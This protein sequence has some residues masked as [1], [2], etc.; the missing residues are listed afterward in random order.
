MFLEQLNIKKNTPLRNLTTFGI[1]GPARYYLRVE[2]TDALLK[3]WGAA[4][5]AGI[6]VFI[7]GGGSNILVSDYGFDGLVIH[8]ATRGIE[9]LA[10]DDKT[11][12]LKAAA[13]EILDDVIAQTT[14]SGWWGIENLSLI[15]GRVGAF[16]IQNVGAYG[17]DAGGVVQSV[18]VWDSHSQTI[19]NLPKSECQFGYRTSIFNTTQRGRYLILHV[20]IKLSK[21]GQPNL[22]YQGLRDFFAKEPPT[23]PGQM[24]SAQIRAAVTRIRKSKL[25]DP[26]E[27]GSAGSF[28]KNIILNEEEFARLQTHAKK[29]LP[30]N[31]ITKLNGFRERF[32]NESGIKIPTAYIIE[33]CGLKGATLGGAALSQNHALIMTNATGHATAAEVMRLARQVRQTVHSQT[34]L[35]IHIEPT[36]VGFSQAELD[37][38]LEL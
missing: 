2:T 10:E 30:S 12:T 37:G 38:Y 8:V 35:A 22:S 32:P 15:P 11:I 19:K 29:H 5:R 9:T 3:A 26:A 17:Q 34:G 21:I 14:A 18:E 36:L 27:I 13:G 16:P 20:V 24:R 4:Q 28:F 31:V 23:A 33:A 1:G 6:P 25:P 7:L